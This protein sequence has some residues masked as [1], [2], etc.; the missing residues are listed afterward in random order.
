MNPLAVNPQGPGC[1]NHASE[2]TRRRRLSPGF[3]SAGIVNF[4][5]TPVVW[6]SGVPCFTVPNSKIVSVAG[7]W[8]LLPS[9]SI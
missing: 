1:A 5:V 3:A 4:C 9:K 6:N 2:N 7:S 8:D